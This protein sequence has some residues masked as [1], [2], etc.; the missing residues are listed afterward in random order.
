MNFHYPDDEFDI[1][2]CNCDWLIIENIN[3]AQSNLIGGKVW[4][5]TLSNWN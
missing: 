5:G 1:F 4:D 3:G 2:F